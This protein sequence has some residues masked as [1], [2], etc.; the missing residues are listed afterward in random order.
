MDPG[1]SEGK[2]RCFSTIFVHFHPFSLVLRVYSIKT[3]AWVVRKTWGCIYLSMSVYSAQYNMHLFPSFISLSAI[4]VP[5]SSWLC[6]KTQPV[7]CFKMLLNIPQFTYTGNFNENTFSN[8]CFIFFEMTI[9]PNIEITQEISKCVNVTILV[10]LALV[11]DESDPASRVWHFT[12]SRPLLVDTHFDVYPIPALTNAHK[13]LS[14]LYIQQF[15]RSLVA[16][17]SPGFFFL[18]IRR[19]F[20]RYRAILGRQ[21]AIGRRRLYFFNFGKY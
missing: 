15:A 8:K 14:R 16:T 11:S 6:A 10:M 19:A 13:S 5:G 2:Y 3:W 21:I 1:S 20:T 18:F 17:T 12:A 9:A 4:H 7:F